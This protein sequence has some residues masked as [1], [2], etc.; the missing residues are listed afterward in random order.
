MTIDEDRDL[1]PMDPISALGLVLTAVQLTS[2]CL[3]V[4][5]KFLGPSKHDKTYVQAIYQNLMIFNGSLKSLEIHYEI[6]EESQARSIALSSIEIP[7]SD[8]EKI[9]KSL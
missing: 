2:S 5:R 9:L 7:M 6:W 3:K 1:L 4:C 8:C